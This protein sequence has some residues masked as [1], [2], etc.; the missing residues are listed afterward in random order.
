MLRCLSGM[1]LSD[2]LLGTSS[3]ELMA[4]EATPPLPGESALHFMLKEIYNDM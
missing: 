1:I 4:T 3:L 2:K